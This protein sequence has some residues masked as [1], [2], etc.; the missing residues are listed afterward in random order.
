MIR[1]KFI[2]VFLYMIYLISDHFPNVFTSL[3]GIR[4]FNNCQRLIFSF[5]GLPFISKRVVLTSFYCGNVCVYY[6]IL[7]LCFQHRSLHHVLRLNVCVV[8]FLLRHIWVDLSLIFNHLVFHC[9]NCVHFW[10][11]SSS[12]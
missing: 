6:S 4:L 1:W 8:F 9:N 12:W 3:P 11:I 7:W 10:W 2:C 5:M